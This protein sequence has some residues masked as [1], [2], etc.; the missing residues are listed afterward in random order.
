MYILRWKYLGHFFSKLH[1]FFFHKK[2]L[3]PFHNLQQE[4]VPTGASDMHIY[5]F[6]W[7]LEGID[8]VQSTSLRNLPEFSLILLKG[9]VTNRYRIVS[10][11]QPSLNCRIWIK[12]HINAYHLRKMP[13]NTE[14]SVFFF[15]SCVLLWWKKLFFLFCANMVKKWNS[16][17]VYDNS[18]QSYS[19]NI[20]VIF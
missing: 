16:D 2:K 6:C 18:L 20:W 10:S 1:L 15:E 7:G 3:E 4:K 17:Q 11:L 19:K 13:R 14:W 5:F 8:Y 9:A 12:L